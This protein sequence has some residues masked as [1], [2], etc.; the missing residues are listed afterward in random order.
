VGA[1]GAD[2]I[3]RL[4]NPLLAVADGPL[5]SRMLLVQPLEAGTHDAQ[6]ATDCEFSD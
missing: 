1:V 6:D 4:D 2:Q 5:A 3:A